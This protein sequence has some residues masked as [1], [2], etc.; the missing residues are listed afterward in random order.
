MTRE[1]RCESWSCGCP[2]TW[3][4][5]FRHQTWQDRLLGLIVD[6]I[7]VVVHFCL[8]LLA[9]GFLVESALLFCFFLA[10]VVF[11]FHVAV[12][13][14]AGT[15]PEAGG[16]VVGS[17]GENV[18]HRVPV[19]APDAEVVGGLELMS[20]PDGLRWSFGGVLRVVG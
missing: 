19:H 12:L 17:G 14:W 11:V 2:E 13:A 20:W 5:G 1:G 6:R 7:F 4:F 10:D 18:A 8:F 15:G 9:G 3:N 16:F